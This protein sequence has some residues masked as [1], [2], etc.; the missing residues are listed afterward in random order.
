MTASALRPV[1]DGRSVGTLLELHLDR[2]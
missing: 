2:L 1:P